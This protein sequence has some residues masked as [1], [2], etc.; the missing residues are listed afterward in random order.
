MK[1]K[2]L[3]LI[4]MIFGTSVAADASLTSSFSSVS[5]TIT[6]GSVSGNVSATGTS[7]SYTNIAS[8]NLAYLG[9]FSYLTGSILGNVFTATSFGGG[10][11]YSFN[12]DLNRS[13]GSGSRTILGVTYGN[14]DVEVG[15]TSSSSGN[16][17]LAGQV[18][19]ALAANLTTS[20]T[21]TAPIDSLGDIAYESNIGYQTRIGQINIGLGGASSDEDGVSQSLTSWGLGFTSHF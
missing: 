9:S 16:F 12:N 4:A 1:T 7:L 14:T 19:F 13:E 10:M 5:G 11:G 17:G 18:G 20:L 21:L 15:S 3:T 2:I 6:A 8:N